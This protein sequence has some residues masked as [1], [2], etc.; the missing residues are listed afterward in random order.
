MIL[1]AGE[2][3][4]VPRPVGSGG[5]FFFFW[6]TSERIVIADADALNGEDAITLATSCR[7]VR[8]FARAPRDADLRSKG[9]RHR[10]YRD[11]AR[12]IA[13][14]SAPVGLI[15]F[16]LSHGTLSWSETQHLQTAG[17]EEWVQH[18]TNIQGRWLAAH[19]GGVALFPLLGMT[20]WWML[21]PLGLAS[22]VS[23]VALIL[24]MPLYIAVDAVL[25]I[26]SSVLIH[27]REGLAPSDRAGADGALEALFFEPSAIDWLDQGASITWQI[28]AL[29]AALA[30]WRGYGWRVSVPLAAAG[31]VLPRVTSHRTGLL[32]GSRSA[33]RCGSTWSSS[34]ASATR[35]TD[36]SPRAANPCCGA[37]P[38]RWPRRHRAFHLRALR[39]SC[40]ARYRHWRSAR[41]SSIQQRG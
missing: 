17:S 37:A 24:Y 11:T 4:L 6:S 18:L 30:L 25:G 28:G 31:W 41:R 8:A 20:I 33:S 35:S 21:P 9:P 2:G 15:A 38:R 39:G 5:V 1:A 16:S 7:R 23:K 36:T 26:G 40:R 3:I 27:Y 32:P 14:I 34:A 12:R 29:A 19:L 13:M 22:R 10:D